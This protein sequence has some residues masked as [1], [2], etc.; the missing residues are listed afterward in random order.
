MKKES[1][2]S[3]LSFITL[4]LAL[5]ANANA[6]ANSSD[7]INF[8]TKD[9]KFRQSGS[10]EWLSASVP[11]NVHT[12]LLSHKK[13]EDPFYRVNEKYLQWIGEKDWEYK[14]DFNIDASTLLKDN[15]NLV[16]KGL[17]TY[18]DVYLN[19]S[20]ILKTDNMHRDWIIDC[21]KILRSGNNALRIYFNS[22]F[23]V[24][25][26]K[27]L[28]APLKLQAWLN[29]DQSDIWLSVY[30][31]KAGF[32]FGWDWGPR[33]IT[34][35][36]WRPV[37]IESWN[38]A[39]I[40]D[41]QMIQNNVS[42]KS[43]KITAVFEI[44]SNKELNATLSIAAEKANLVQK[45]VLL[46]PGMN[47]IPVEFEI[48]NPKL[49]W[50]NG[51]GKPNM[52][53]FDCSLK[54]V[55]I[56]DNK[57]IKTGI[58]SLKIVT[59]KDARG[60]S[61]YVLLNGVPVFMKGSNY[62]PLDNF[63]NRVTYE[64]YEYY[65]KAA[66]E[67]NMNMLRVWGGGIYEEDMFYDLCDKYGI[68]VWQDIMFACGM[69]PVDDDFINT[70][71]A[72]VSQ[73]VKRL[74][75]HPSIAL[76]NGNNENEMSWFAWGWKDLY[77]EADQK[78]YGSNLKKLFYDV[79]PNAIYQSDTTRY[80]H[81]TS[82]NTYYNNI[83]I[84]EGD[85]HYWDTK[86]DAPLTSYNTFIGRFMSEY[87][88][89]SYPDI[90]TIEKFTQPWERNK[91]SEVLFAHNRAK[92]DNTRDPNFGNNVIENKMK[93][94]YHI[95]EKFESYVYTSQLLHAKATKMAIEAHRRNMPF[96]MGTL[97]WQL[98]DC[99]PAVSWS[100]IDFY[101]NW[102]AAQYTVREVYKNIIAPVIIEEGKLRVYLVS[103]SLKDTK[104]K[105]T[106][107]IVNL[108]GESLYNK[109]ENIILAA[110]TSKIYFETDTLQLLKNLDKK[111]IALVVE[112]TEG[113]RQ[114][115]SNI[116]YFVPEKEISL[117]KPNIV[118]TTAQNG[119]QIDITLKTDVLAKSVYLSF[120]DNEGFFSD[121]YFDLMPG[122][123]KKLTFKSTTGVNVVKQ[124]LLVKSLIDFKN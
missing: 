91:T 75:N 89:Q 124:A 100:S 117:S 46:K 30:S 56:E 52:Y 20:L 112:V 81:P 95:P 63:Q 85:V 15:V 38:T 12:D 16:F 14:T 67:S 80:C 113:A 39:K 101:G 43:A 121:N 105:L 69:F 84:S 58:R 73:N 120:P 31:R 71:K 41:V 59:E 97:Y 42:E 35:G 60:K 34:C 8:I 21:K 93:V 92:H 98:N 4:F 22:V 40:N 10:N 13:I 118:F 37:Y 7:T 102:K 109:Q 11:G 76:W 45:K 28:A 119:N 23:K 29:N 65:I 1:I 33:L 106:L 72:E 36:I 70:V 116:F 57:S 66:A 86:G 54:T 19:D 5:F 110:N 88:F 47:K 62:I 78:I 9:W 6:L 51:L 32:H 87:G 90:K 26:P 99:W 111:N 104:A 82:P 108:K 94:Y 123:I 25:I 17:D 115:A 68:L 61:L 48:K 77:N 114:L 96:C 53:T 83:P 18:A 122:E 49:W 50:S 55:E 79:V 27:Y 74:R 64:K 3:L 44:N 107:K 103:D 24:N 2:T